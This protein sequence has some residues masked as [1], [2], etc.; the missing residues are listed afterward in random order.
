MIKAKGIVF[1]DGMREIRPE[2]TQEPVL[3]YIGV[4]PR[5]CV[6]KKEKGR[7]SPL[8]V[9]EAL[10]LISCYGPMIFGIIFA[11]LMLKHE[12]L[13]ITYWSLAFIWNGIVLYANRKGRRPIGE[14]QRSR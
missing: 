11:T 3:E 7:K 9:R 4:Q 8:S 1:G 10:I 2:T 14:R 6:S 13:Y 12:A 5:R